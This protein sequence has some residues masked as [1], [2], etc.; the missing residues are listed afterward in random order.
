M[1]LRG[2]PSRGWKF[3]PEIA[4]AVLDGFFSYPA[5]GSAWRCED[6]TIPPTIS[7]KASPW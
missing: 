5:L 2:P 1:D 7:P 3:A 4:A 6:T